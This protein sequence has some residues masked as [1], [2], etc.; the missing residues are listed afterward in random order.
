MTALN[1]SSPST[2]TF[3]DIFN[4]PMHRQEERITRGII[5]TGLLLTRHKIIGVE[6]PMDILKGEE[7]IIV[8]LNHNSRLEAIVVEALLFLIREGRPVHFMADWN[9]MLVPLVASLY[10]RAETIIVTSKDNKIKALNFLKPY[11]AKSSFERALDKLKEGGALGFFPEG[12]MNRDP[13]RLM[14]GRSGAVK[15]SLQSGTPILPI[16]IRFPELDGS[17]PITDADKMSLHIGTPINPPEIHS[18]QLSVQLV[19]EHHQ[20]VMKALSQLCGKTWSKDANKR[21][22]YV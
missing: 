6:G 21:R 11:Y 9:F 7:P 8:V 22:R 16:G 5:K 19:D 13:K 2:L 17:R 14:Y 10:R 1:L 20:T 12:T 4:A 3:R 18:N 15:I